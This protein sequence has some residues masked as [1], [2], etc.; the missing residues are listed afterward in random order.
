MTRRTESRSS[1]TLMSL[2]ALARATRSSIATGPS[3][4]SSTT[5]AMGRN[6]SSNCPLMPGRARGSGRTDRSA[7][8]SITR[9]RHSSRIASRVTTTPARPSAG[10]NSE[11]K[12]TSREP[13]EPSRASI[14]AMR[15]RT[16]SGSRAMW[17]VANIAARDITSAKAARRSGSE[18]SG[19]GRQGSMALASTPATKKSRP[20]RGSSSRASAARRN[21]SY[22]WRRRT[23]SARGSASPSSSAAGRGSRRRDLISARVAAITRYSPASSRRSSRISSTYSTYWR[24]I[25]A[26]GMLR[27]SRFWRR[28]RYRRRSSG[29][30]N[31]SMNTSSASGGM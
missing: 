5:S 21:R 25:S 17:W 13:A 31:A 7:R 1:C 18:T 11:V 22:S 4:A 28:M 2:S 8:G 24:V 19:G 3:A 15:S 26:M 29:P 9:S 23:R 10:V 27:M 30:S 14:V 12:S 20:S 16:D 6:S